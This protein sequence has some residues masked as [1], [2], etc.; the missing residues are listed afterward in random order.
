MKKSI[1][2]R[3]LIFLVTIVSFALS[4]PLIAQHNGTD[5]QTTGVPV[6]FVRTWDATAPENNPNTLMARS[7]K[8]V[9]MATQYFDGLG[10]P[11]QTV[12]KQGSL[13]TQPVGI[14]PAATDM[15]SAVEYDEF[16]R[17][18]YKWLPYAEASANNGAF[19]TS[20]F[21]AQLS[22]YNDLNGVLKGQG[23]SYYY[24]KAVFE[25][26]PLNRIEK[27]MSPGINWAGAS[28]GVEQKYWTNTTVDDVKM[29][30]VTNV[31]NSFGI[32]ALN[33]TLNSYG[34]YNAGEL[35]KT[36]AVDEHSKQVIEFKD[37]EGKIIL[38]KI[39]LTATADDGTG[40][41]YFGWLSTYYMYDDLGNLRCVIQPEAVKAMATA[42]NWALSTIQLNEQCFRY[43]Y[44]HRNRMIMKKIPGAGTF[45]LVYDKRDRLVMTQDANM[46]IGSPAKWLVT[47]YDN[48]NRPVQ[49]GLWNDANNQSYHAAQA[50]AGSNYYYPFDATTL[51]T[52]GWEK[53]TATHYDN[54][55]GLPSPSSSAFN[56]TWNS[57]FALA[58]NSNYPYPQAL[59]T[60]S[61]TLGL[62]T[63]TETKILDGNN[64]FILTVLL[65]DD[66]ARVIQSQA[67]NITGGVD[68][69]TTQYNWAGQPLTI[70][71]KSAKGGS[72]NPQT[73]VIVTKMNYDPLGRVA[74][75]KKTVNSI[76]NGTAV[77]KAE[78]LVAEYQYDKLGKLKKKILA[79]Q[80]N[81]NAG[82][83]TE[84]FEYN[85]RGWMLGMNREYAKD[86]DN[87]NY[88]GFDLGY[89]KTNNGIIGNKSY[90]KAEYNGNIAGMVWKS[91]GDE[92][93]RKYDFDYD[94]ANRLMKA[95]FTQYTNSAFNQ[96]ADVKFDVLMGDGSTLSNGDLDP[97]KAYDDNG[98][99]KQMQQWGF[100]INTSF[101]IDNLIYS[102]ISGSNKLKLVTDISNDFGSKLGDFK[103]DPS[104]KTNTDFTYDDNGNLT[105]DVNKNLTSIDYN[106]LNLPSLITKPSPVDAGG[107]TITYIY[108]AAGKKLQKIV[109]STCG[110]SCSIVTTTT[111]INGFVYESKTSSTENYTD[112]LQFIAQEEGRIRFN[113]AV[114]SI[115]ADFQFDYMLKDHLG[116]V[117][118]ILTEEQK[119]D[120]YPAA[121]METAQ[122]TTEENFYANLNTTREPKPSGYPVDNTTSPNDYVAR[123]KAASGSQKIGP[124]II[125]KVMA[126]DKF[127]VKV[128]SWYKTN[129]ASPGTPVNPLADLVAALTTNIGG[130]TSTH[131]GITVNQLQTSGVLSP[132]ASQF[133]N[134]QSSDP[135]RPKAYLNWILLDEQFNIAKDPN[136]NIMAN[137]YSG[138]DQVPSEAA[139]GT[140]T[141][142]NV[143]EQ[144]FN[145]LAINKSGYLYVYVSNETPNIDVF[146][147]NLQVIHTRGAILEETH[148]YPFGLIMSGI[149]S[150]AAVPILNKFQFAGK[151]KQSNE[152][153][154]GS[155]LELI[156]FGA[157]LHDPQL[158]MWHN[159]DPLS[160]ISRRW[161]P[162]NYAFSN[163]LRFID[164]DGLAVEEINDGVRYT[165]KDAQ[166][167]FTEI[168][169]FYAG[170][171]T[172]K[173]EE[174]DPKKIA[175]GE[176]KNENNP[177]SNFGNYIYDKF[178]NSVGDINIGEENFRNV[179]KVLG[180][181]SNYEILK[182]KVFSPKNGKAGEMYTI[183]K[184]EFS[185]EVHD[186][187]Y[188]K[189][190]KIFVT[191]S[192]IYTSEGKP[193][194]F[195][196]GIVVNQNTFCYGAN[197]GFY[198]EE[199]KQDFMEK[200][201]D[202][203][204]TWRGG[205]HTIDGST[206]NYDVK[207]VFGIH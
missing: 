140:A 45:Y 100:R 138:A 85:I 127:D 69:I 125:L 72:A 17:E 59:T 68:I 10:R 179:I 22:F 115:A 15:V 151:E 195:I 23:E 131:G 162:Y 55:S 167:A 177:I 166:S 159:I 107:G 180:K 76:I 98:N 103:Y 30:T 156:D 82:L 39:Q 94:A 114:G 34:R 136:G 158:G 122:T 105:T 65:Y 48:L 139:F 108:D 111:Y 62:P 104:T 63:W 32:Y 86:N 83:E 2:Q 4:Q 19:K 163:P 5:Y 123:V 95:D 77:N 168:K 37:K 153:S 116:N 196:T 3:L 36:V 160:D 143:Y 101:L 44:D 128:S 193:V 58:S 92:E 205:Y 67:T 99:I 164:P 8:D 121:T 70:V 87:S 154:D 149:S 47:L 11:L 93:K 194:G 46:R 197:G 132:N 90:T 135:A 200:I 184:Y 203:G 56:S 75:I 16:G 198:G 96:T 42:N 133:L 188:R 119:V 109:N 91:R 183:V 206:Y 182:T 137:G 64:N 169:T 126:G 147:D 161:S 71:Q 170:I 78:Q 57:Y 29:W 6:N 186:F 106:F 40:K 88:F 204:K 134:S 181:P 43:E 81:S 89:D 27:S 146:F 13:A 142:P 117:R 172:E 148:Y 150:K 130:F 207:L 199:C 141:N 38:K 176:N 124:S 54:Y 189:S 173:K 157:R 21:T 28:R 35:Y 51:P 25:P 84:N 33:I 185:D 155:G 152:F 129:G 174:N 118:A 20:P 102:Y 31:A 50:I 112:V 191:A 18:Q 26:S 49:T 190:S 192:V 113:P 12:I 145:N 52:T 97:T 187:E 73:H 80:Y 7:L 120:H 66:K 9:K 202:R 1:R 74:D 53:L 201:S 110:S 165:G 60:A 171:S 175:T 14:E 144:G 79:P 178:F 41:D 61:N 24:S